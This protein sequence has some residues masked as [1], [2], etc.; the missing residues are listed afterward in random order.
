M[1]LKNLLTWGVFASAIIATVLPSFSAEADLGVAWVR[2]VPAIDGGGTVEGSLHVMSGGAITLNGGATITRDLMVPGTPVVRANGKPNYGGTLD[3]PGPVAPSGYVI[4]LNGQSTLRNVIRR[5]APITLPSVPTPPAPAG[6]RNVVINTAA[7]PAGDWTTLRNLTLNGGVGQ[8]AVPPGAYGDFIAN[9]GSGFTLGIAGATTPAVYHLQGLSLNGQARVDVVGP[10]VLNLARGLAANGVIGASARPD[11]LSL[12]IASGGLTLNGGCSVHA[13]VAA[14]AAGSG[15]VIV[16]GNG[17]LVG[18]LVADSLRVNGGGLLRLRQGGGSGPANTAPVALSQSLSTPEDTPLALTL[19]ATDAENDPL[20]YRLVSLPASGTL[21]YAGGGVPPAVDAALSSTDLRYTPAADSVEPVSF[22]FRVRDGAGLESN[23]ATISLAVTPVNDVPVA[24]PLVVRTNEDTP[25]AIT[26]SG[27]DRDGSIVAYTV[28]PFASSSG[29][30]AGTSASFQGSLTGEPPALTYVPKADFAGDETFTYT[31]TDDLGTVSPP[32][33]VMI[34]VDPVN[35]RPTAHPQAIELAEDQPVLIQLA[36]ADPEGRAITYFVESL[37]A[38]G[39]LALADGTELPAIGEPLPDSGDGAR[40]R[41]IPGINRHDPDVFTFTASDGELRSEP[42][43]IQL[44]ILSVNDAPVASPGEAATREDAA[45]VIPLDVFDVDGDELR[46]DLATPPARGT[47]S[48]S[49][50]LATY[51][52]AADYDGP[53]SFTFTVFDGSVAS[54]PARINVEVAP[55][56]DAPST[57]PI[58]AQSTAEDTELAFIV[59]ASDADGDPL[60]LHLA[61]API[62][63]SVKLAGGLDFPAEGVPLDSA[64]CELRYSPHADYHG[65]DELAFFV[66]DPFEARSA[67]LPVPITVTPVNDA[68]TAHPSVYQIDE[69]QTLPLVLV[70]T[71][72]DG[73]ELT[74]AVTTLPAAGALT[75]QDGTAIAAQVSFPASTPLRYAPPGNSDTTVEFTFTV[76]DGAATSAPA[77]VAVEVRN[78]PDAPT[79]DSRSLELVEDTSLALTLTATDPEGDVLR[80]EVIVPPAHGMLSGEEPSLVYTP[81]SDFHG[82]DGFTFVVRDAAL[83]SAP[84][85][86]SLVVTP[87]NDAPHALPQRLDTS[88]DAGLVFMLAGFDPD[89]DPIICALRTL[90][91]HGVLTLADGGPLPELGASLPADGLLRYTPNSDYHGVDAFE[92]IVTDSSG[93]ASAPGSVV[94]DVAPV[95]DAPVAL[96]QSLIARRNTPLVFSL[97]ATDADGDALSFRLSQAPAHG[98]L[99]LVGEQA[100]YSPAE[101]YLGEDAFSFIANDGETDSLPATV[102]VAVRLPNNAPIVHAGEDLKVRFTP[103]VDSAPTGR[104]IVN[105]DEWVLTDTGFSS[106]PYA[107]RFARNVADFLTGGKPGSRFFIYTNTVAGSVDF[108]YTGQGFAR[109]MAEAGHTLVKSATFPANLAALLEYDAIFLSANIVDNG[110]LIDYVE[111]GGSVYLSGGTK[112]CNCDSNLEAAWWNGFLNYFGL[113]Y[114]PAYN[115]IVGTLPIDSDHPLLAGISSLYFGNGNSVFLFNPAD[116]FAQVVFSYQRQGLLAVYG[117]EKNQVFLRGSASD[118]GKPTPPGALTTT[119][120]QTEGPP[121]VIESAH[122]LVTRVSFSSRGIYR[123]RLIGTDGEVESS[124]DVVV[125]VNEPPRV[126]AG[127]SVAVRSISD[128]GSLLGSVADD[129]VGLQLSISW[130]VVSGPGNVVF[131][132][133]NDAVTEVRVDAPGTYLLKLTV[134]DGLESASD[135]VKLQAGVSTWPAP[136]EMIAWWPFD[137]TLED[138]VSGA[139]RFLPSR[140]P[141]FSAG[142]VAEGLNFVAPDDGAQLG[143]GASLDLGSYADGFSIE[144][145]MKAPTLRDGTILSFGETGKQGLTITEYNSGRELLVNLRDAVADRY[146]GSGTIL[147]AGKW[148]H[149]ALTYDRREGRAR[150]YIDRLLRSEKAFGVITPLTSPLLVLGK[151]AWDGQFAWTGQLDE[152]AFYRRALSA[153]EIAK[154]YFAGAGGKSTAAD[155]TAPRVDAGPDLVLSSVSGVAALLGSVEDDAKPFGD[156]SVEW[157]SVSGP[158]SVSFSSFVS[159]RT[160][161][162]FSEPGLYVLRLTATDGFALPVSDTV[163]VRVGQMAAA[164]VEGAAAWWPLN[165]HAR[166]VIHGVCDFEL[167]NGLGYAPAKVATGLAYDG[168]NDYA[169][170]SAHTDLDLGASADGLS[171]ELW[172]KPSSYRDV[173]LVEWA[174]LSGAQSSLSQW[175]AGRGLYF[176]LRA[177]DTDV[178]LLAF[179]N[180]LTLDVWQHVVATY[181]RRTGFARLYRDGVL[182]AEQNLGVFRPLTDKDFYLGARPRESRWYHGTLDEPT[183]YPRPLEVAEVRA[184]FSAG[185]MGKTPFGANI[186]PAVDAGGDRVFRFP[187]GQVGLEGSVLDDGLPVGGAFKAE[188]VQLSGPGAASFA[189]AT[190]PRTVVEL[191]LPGVYVFELRAWDGVLFGKD[192]VELRVGVDAVEAPAAMAAWWPLNAHPE[193][194]VGGVSRLQL[195]NGLGY[196]TGKVA[197]GLIYDG[198]DDFARTPARAGLDV[199]SSAGGMTVELWVNPQSYRDTPLI[200]WG[201]SVGGQTCLSQ[202]NVGR[203][204]YFFLMGADGV[205]RQ[206]AVDN[207]FTT[208]QWQHVVATYDR[209]SGW[210]R[211]YRNAHLLSEQNLG[212][213]E[214][215]TTKDFYVGS[216][217]RERRWFHGALDEVALYRRALSG[218]EVAGLYA[219]GAVGRAPLDGNA[220]PRVH[221]GPD[222]ESASLAVSLQGTVQDDGLPEAV[223]LALRWSQIAGPGSVE[224]DD[225]GALSTT[226]NFSQA[227]TYVLELRANDGILSST[228]L[229]EVRVGVAPIEAPLDLEAWWPLNAHGLEV[230]KQNCRLELFNGLGYGPGKVA[231]G[232]QFDGSND[233]AR[234]GAHGDMN[235]GSSSQGMTVELWVN[236]QSYRDTPLIEWGDS[237]GGQTCLSQWNVGRGLYFFLM[238]SDGVMRYAGVDNVL[239]TNQWQHV[240]ATFDRANGRVRL[241]RNGQMLAE[242]SLGVFE[243]RTTKDFYVGGRPR[244]GRWFHGSIDEIALYS[245]PLGPD[246]IDRQFAAGAAG[247]KPLPENVAPKL[248]VASPVDVFAGE[249]REISCVV[250]DDGLPLGMTLTVEWSKISGPGAVLFLDSSSPV[251]TATF[252]MPGSYVLKVD[253]FDGQLGSS[254]EVLVEVEARAPRVALI[255]P[256]EGTSLQANRPLR[257]VADASIASGSIERVEFYRGTGLIGVVTSPSLDVGASVYILTMPSG[258]PAGVHVLTARAIALGSGATT[259]SPPVSVTAVPYAGPEIVELSAPLDGARITAPTEF[260][261]IVARAGLASWK[262]EYRLTPVDPAASEA[263]APWKTFATGTDYV[264]TPASGSVTA[265]PSFLGTLDPT[266]LLNGL[267]QVRLSAASTDGTTLIAGPIGVLVEG[268]MKV[269]AFSV[270]FNDLVE[271][272]PGLPITLTRTYDS[273]DRRV[274]DFGPGWHLSLG[275]IRVQ[276]NRHLGAGWWQTPQA[277]DGIQFYDVLPIDDRIVTVVMP[278]GETHRFRAG[279]YVKNRS[280]DPDYRSFA[281]LVRDGSYRFYPVGDTTSTLEPITINGAGEPILA[282]RFWLDGTGD[283]DLYAGDYGDWDYIPYNPTQFRLTTADGTVMLL[284]QALGLLELRDRNGN[285]LVIHRHPVSAGAA[286]AGRIKSIDSVQAHDNGPITRTVE[287]SRHA[288]GRID[289]ITDLAGR[290]LDYLY[291]PQGRLES[292]ADR[293]DHTTQFRYEKSQDP[294]HPLFHYLTK[295]IDPRGLPALRCEYDDA[296][297]L[298]KQIDADGRETVFDRGIDPDFGRYERITDRLGHPTTYFYDERGNIRTKIDALEAVTTYDY[299]PDSDRVK[300]EEDHYGNVKGFAYDA[301]GNVTVEIQ[302]A[303]RAE[304]PAAASTGYITRSSYTS[305]GAPLSISDPDGRLQSF[306]YDPVT[307]QLLNH[308]VGQLVAGAHPEIETAAPA[309]TTYTY[310]SDGTLWTVTD[311]LGN[312]TTTTYDYGYTDAVF[313]GAVKRVTTTVV[314]PAGAA[315][316]DPTNATATTL[317]TSYAYH[318]AQENLLA[319]VTLRTLADGSIEAIPTRHVYDAENRL[320]FT[321]LPD[322][323]VSETRYT[324]FGQTE[325]TLEWPVGTDLATLIAAGPSGPTSGSRITSF[326]YDARG[327]LERTT[328]PDGTYTA[329][330]YDLESRPLW[331]QDARGYRTFTVYDEVGRPRFT[332]Q[333]DADDGTFDDAPASADDARLVNNPRTETIYDLVGRVRFQIDEEGA[334]TEFTYDDHCGCAMRRKEMIQHHPEGNL[335]TRYEYYPSGQIRSVTDPRGNTIGTRYDSHGRPVRTLLPATEEYPATETATTYNVLGQRVAATDQEGKLTRYRHDGLGRLLEVRQYLDQALAASDAAFTLPVTAVGLVSTRYAYDEAGNQTAQTD[336]RDHV[337]RYQHDALGRRLKRTLPA[338]D[339]AAKFESFRYD[340]WGDLWQRDDFAGRT[341][342]FGY[343]ELHRLTSKQA[344][345][346]HPSLAYS[347]AV[348]RVEYDHDDNGAREAARTYNASGDLL[349]T[350]HTPRDERGRVDYKDTAD[351]R[352]DYDYYE[353][354]LL[355][356]IVSATSGGV[357]LGY[358]YDELNRL[359]HVDDASR[360]LPVRTT[361]YAYN[362]NGS[363]EALTYANGLRHVYRYD[364]LNRLRLLEVGAAVP[365]G[366]GLVSVLQSYDYR[367]RASG[368]RREVA[369]IGTTAATRTVTYGYDALYRLTSEAIGGSG[370]G[371]SPVGSVSYTLDKVGNREARNSTLPSVGS[372][373]G[374]TFNARDQLSSDSY[375]ANGNTAVGQTAGLVSAPAAPDVYDFEDRLIVRT[376]ADLSRIYLGYDADG[377]RIGKTIHDA[378]S[379]LVSATSYLVCTNNLTGYA[380]VLEERKT[381]AGGT[382][383]RTYAYG[384]DLLSVDRSGS[385]IPPVGSVE[386]RYFLYDGGGSV[387]A[388]ADESGAITDR[389][390]YDAFGVLLAHQGT[391]DNAYLYRGEQYDADLGL[392]YLRARFYN[393]DSGRFWNQDTYEGRN[394]D[395]ASLHKY[396]YAHANPVRYFDPSGNFSLAEIGHASGIAAILG[397]MAGAAYGGLKTRSFYGAAKYA[398][399]GAVSAAAI[400]ALALS[401]GVGV[402]KISGGA[403]TAATASSVI[404]STYSLYAIY[405]N[406]QALVQ[407]NTEQDQQAA[408]FALALSLILQADATRGLYVRYSQTQ[409]KM[410]SRAFPASVRRPYIERL[411]SAAGLRCSNCD[412]PL[413]PGTQSQRGVSPAR[414]EI[415]YDHVVPYSQGGN[416]SSANVQPLCFS[417]NGAKSN[418]F[419]LS[420]FEWAKAFVE[421]GQYWHETQSMEEEVP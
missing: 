56:N 178:R 73:D 369:E 136:A 285:R 413:I 241:Y 223:P 283:Q 344:D 346:S 225:S 80:Y 144:F 22:T 213:F 65:P 313:P 91:E 133:I 200:E 379:T 309:T 64:G 374:L 350:E 210:V 410:R 273:R 113:S 322:G 166:E 5:T 372:T 8:V 88:E 384:S 375:D 83:E 389:Y 406:F 60:V 275:N 201:D 27:F 419:P 244:E 417:C 206:A 188:W 352:L 194:V 399:I 165:S 343:D 156:P 126:E 347:H 54:A 398:A 114:S 85:I 403:I 4:T 358:R 380:Q 199:G 129:G 53:D 44:T 74:C 329:T 247:K 18:G 367:L 284:D 414:N 131:K 143:T 319:S 191:P 316:S 173:S 92:F 137:H 130:S 98:A 392:T 248:Q 82:T 268:N 338:V 157:T 279:A 112:W 19:T 409:G 420:S 278:D 158:G 318:D 120:V 72:V 219:A 296:G 307:Q 152:L 185:A 66:T 226:V 262:L 39:T 405:A 95:N 140:A 401:G 396:L 174:S 164:A 368:H 142:K 257:L 305:F 181:D 105:N 230:V 365:G 224:F 55:E 277:G 163:E 221:A 382:T 302:G 323:R 148:T 393:P 190:N 416:S 402:A 141:V 239:T 155:N 13:H 33:S 408:L 46:Y 109:V 122:T 193:E 292:F 348:A 415:R 233:F 77:A 259:T 183:L 115:Q 245:R 104:I 17:V 395:P 421:I 147:E 179:D 234:T 349:Y 315:G 298:L 339:G 202:W 280:G 263:G 340:T 182:L 303:S 184:L 93:A 266:L 132:S 243:A 81:D 47:V 331:R 198:V 320:R 267:Y 16:N 138:A 29:S 45:V 258:F 254:A 78:I 297:R 107:G 274:G 58:P 208:N 407:A 6:T 59:R 351:A 62:H 324:S 23:L 76:S 394:T 75:F 106:S 172:L 216:R 36:A 386:T 52:P 150:L 253:A 240:A 20:V 385:D 336:A 342:T 312:V 28:T 37:P 42:A 26:L 68:P 250:E 325:K 287:I 301:R 14:P 321:I 118:D 195:F 11:W 217:P 100:I 9:G 57:I 335:V 154:I 176:F 168:V 89:G 366:V 97:L 197:Q 151:N 123:F 290:A 282:D 116:T 192:L 79:A 286:L 111:A 238:G 40:L 7:Q 110:L 43:A 404:S 2:Q 189:D 171:I 412:Q 337:T 288:D 381:D 310:H 306:T 101:G 270:A 119:W 90:P 204:L 215:R 86:V 124:D 134:S 153:E 264:G 212:S 314:D 269:G 196:G 355:K 96:P 228:D 373:A 308:T 170:A 207:V 383:L 261:G 330:G 169:R 326:A 214:V 108:A 293:E 30:D 246:E 231:Q 69:R 376:R 180:A 356:D 400:T 371:V 50:N 71:D 362:G 281:T 211:L 12:N 304:E 25:V 1:P 103:R 341:T 388:L 125:Y 186:A 15:A 102:T 160:D 175:N 187:S 205:V 391:S 229:M 311:A 127:P 295:I 334:T 294:A 353:N 24:A 359:A 21:S 167:H 357:N 70:G 222:L 10:V 51:T 333:P 235:M 220:A 117:N 411:R 34:V 3:G 146:I 227:G 232:L 218:E 370:T 41:Y 49:G 251:T 242:R 327:N 61:T 255:S 87:V 161:A 299:Y 387:R 328:L 249:P 35:D 397:G 48:I 260:T 128:S 32:A 162:T 237:V 149:V 145:W 31:V 236:P 354:G 252:L 203:G 67:A 209:A 291:D 84:A 276:K 332:I 159:A 177:S 94:I 364:S 300:F 135:T 418:A 99:E 265:E 345:P 272:T 121:A 317:R 390:T 38:H 271:Q 63:G 363:L 378:A 289:Y 256:V 360:G 377:I 361:S 139:F